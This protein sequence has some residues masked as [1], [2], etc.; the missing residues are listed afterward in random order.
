MQSGGEVE[1]CSDEFHLAVTPQNLT[2][3]VRLVSEKRNTQGKSSI[4]GESQRAQ[5]ILTK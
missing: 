2:K 4:H 5:E 1:I 3:Y